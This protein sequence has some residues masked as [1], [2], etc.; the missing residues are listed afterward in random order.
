MLVRVAVAAVAGAVVIGAAIAVSQRPR[1]VTSQDSAQSISP[2]TTTTVAAATSSPEAS[3]QGGTTAQAVG[4]PRAAEE[5][6]DALGRALE[7]SDWSALERL[8]GPEGWNAGFS[9]SSGTPDMTASQ[10][11]AWLRERIIGDRLVVSVSERPIAMTGESLARAFIWSEWRDFNSFQAQ[12]NRTP[13]Q[14]VQL[15]LAPS[16]DGRWFWRTA[17]FGFPISPPTPVPTPAYITPEEAADA[18]KR[19]LEQRD[20]QLLVH[21]VAPT[22]WYARWYEQTETQPMPHSEAVGWLMNY[23]DAIRTVEARPVRAAGPGHPRGDVYVR[24]LWLDFGGFPEQKA[25]I[26]LGKI[27]NRWYWT[28]LLLYRPPPIGLSSTTFN[29]YA[30]LTAISDQTLTVRFRTVGS[31]CCSDQSFDG[32]TVTLRREGSIAWMRAGGVQASSFADTGATIGSDAW[33]A[34]ELDSRAADGS[35]RLSMF[36]PMYP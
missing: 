18:V 13:S 29:G 36:A 20:Y 34:F 24:S 17:V 28:S 2:S 8:I 32:R 19:A 27:G 3:G 12:P 21:V 22:G 35:Y 6:A 16:G 1:D 9:G 11:I 26:V 31:L 25:D 7:G 10:A 4:V 23:P 15:I 14:R 33:V 5:L 30:T